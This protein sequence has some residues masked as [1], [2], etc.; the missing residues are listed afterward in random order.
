MSR[1]V[2]NILKEAEDS[3]DDFFQ[4]KHINKRFEDLKKELEKKKIEIP[5]KLT[6]DLERIRIS[7]KNKNWKDEKEELF[8]KLFSKLHVDDAFYKDKYRYGYYLL[9]SNDKR[10]CFYNLK[11]NKF[12]IDYD[13]IW[14]VFEIRFD[15][16]YY[17]IQSFMDDMLKEHFK[18]YDVTA[19]HDVTINASTLKEHF[20]L[21]DVTAWSA[22]G[23]FDFIA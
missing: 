4:S 21:Y 20:K 2:N 10:K 5:S 7:Y 14:I 6:K 22:S 12:W 8:L 13:S 15:M 17:D 19:L 1:F 3:S 18:L 11:N 23:Y 9:D 16:Y